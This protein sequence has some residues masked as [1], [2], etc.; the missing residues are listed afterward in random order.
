MPKYLSCL[1]FTPKLVHKSDFRGRNNCYNIYKIGDRGWDFGLMKRF[2]F[3]LI[4]IPI[5]LGGCG[6]LEPANNENYQNEKEKFTNKDELPKTEAFQHEFTR[7]FLV[8]TEEVEEGYYLFESKTGGYQMLFPINATVDGGR[9][10][11]KSEDN[12]LETVHISG[13][14]GNENINYYIKIRYEKGNYT[15]KIDS[16]L[17]LISKL[18]DYEGDFE[19]YTVAGKSIYFGE[20]V[21]DTDDIVEGFFF[22]FFSLYKISKHRSRNFN[23]ICVFCK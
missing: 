5:L 14:Y 21:L 4:L 17:N 22:M 8:S 3:I 13:S 1:N 7:E 23:I 18:Y 12:T 10:Y 2:L 19:E 11:S 6:G 20:Y 9:F 15:N 16:N